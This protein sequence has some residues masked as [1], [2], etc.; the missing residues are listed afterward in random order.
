MAFSMT[1]N[2]C[3]APH[4]TRGRTLAGGT[5]MLNGASIFDADHI[6]AAFGEKR[7]TFEAARHAQKAD[8]HP[9]VG[10]SA[11]AGDSRVGRPADALRIVRPRA[12]P[13][14]CRILRFSRAH[15]T[16]SPTAISLWCVAPSGSPRGF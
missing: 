2:P 8:S 6:C 14:L 3:S 9:D 5:F 4:L 12:R 11:A 16:R 10:G 7:R 1:P 15:S 13:A